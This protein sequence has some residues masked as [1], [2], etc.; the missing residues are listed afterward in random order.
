MALSGP[1]PQGFP[2]P[3]KEVP[4]CSGK[5]SG[6]RCDRKAQAATPGDDHYG[7]APCRTADNISSVDLRLVTENLAMAFTG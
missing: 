4:F 2:V 7:C 3:S 5:R 6:S 1:G